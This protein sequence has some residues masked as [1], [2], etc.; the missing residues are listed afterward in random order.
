MD[1]LDIIASWHYPGKS[2]PCRDRTGSGDPP[3]FSSREGEPPLPSLHKPSL[4][5]P[6]TM[7]ASKT[8]YQSLKTLE[9]TTS[10]STSF[11]EEHAPGN[12]LPYQTT[13]RSYRLLSLL[14]RL[15][16]ILFAIWGFLS[17]LITVDHGVKPR[18][19]DVYRPATFPKNYS[20]CDC[21]STVAEAR[22]K[23]CKYDSMGQHGCP[24][25]VGTMNSLPPLHSLEQN[26]MGPGPTLQT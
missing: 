14:P 7:Q 18:S 15:V 17:L 16:V 20:H 3:P 25:T 22:A 24:N 1:T 5:S 23:G 19:T 26:Q 2:N 21:G 12:I 11:D 8:A 4:R 13:K 10:S 9:S 6:Q